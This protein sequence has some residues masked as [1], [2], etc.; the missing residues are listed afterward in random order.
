MDN[1]PTVIKS[2]GTEHPFTFTG[3]APSLE[4]LQRAVGGYIEVISIPTNHNAVM[5]VNEEGLLERQPRNATA[6]LL[7][8]R[9]IVGNVIVMARRYIEVTGV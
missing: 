1:K 4:E 5:I 2:D 6:S 7:A 8:Q 3:A 9:P